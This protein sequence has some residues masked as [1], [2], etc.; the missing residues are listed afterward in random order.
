MHEHVIGDGVPGVV[1]ADESSSSAAAA[2]PRNASCVCET[3]INADIPSKAYPI[4]GT[5]Q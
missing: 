1:D 5:A 2:T 4:R 3:A